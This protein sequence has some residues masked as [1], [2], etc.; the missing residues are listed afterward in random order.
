M[1]TKFIAAGVIEQNGKYLIAQRAKKDAYFGLWEFPG[2]KLEGNE[3]LQECLQ[4]ELREEL[5][6]HAQVGEF[7]CTS[8]FTIQDTTY[9]MHV[10]K[11][12]SFTGEIKLNDHLAIAWVAADELSQYTYPAPDL[13]IIELL[14]KIS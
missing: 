4:R 2:G 6:I 12:P 14:Q 1:K 5:D 7:L 13:P 3:T 10:F 8:I 9:E 11:V